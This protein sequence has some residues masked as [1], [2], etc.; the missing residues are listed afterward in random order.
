MVFSALKHIFFL[1]RPM[2]SVEERAST[3]SSQSL[4]RAFASTAPTDE[5][6][7]DLDDASRVSLFLALLLTGHG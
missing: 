1:D 5:T 6:D 4:S 3:L 2:L 7:S